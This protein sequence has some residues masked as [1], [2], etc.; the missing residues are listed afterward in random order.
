VLLQS[1]VVSFPLHLGHQDFSLT[2][3]EDSESCYNEPNDDRSD[4]AGS[5]SGDENENSNNQKEDQNEQKD[6]QDED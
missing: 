3:F 6:D 2:P 4:Y 1:S 5:K